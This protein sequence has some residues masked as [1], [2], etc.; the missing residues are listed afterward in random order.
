MK[1]ILSV[2]LFLM[3]PAAAPSQTASDHCSVAADKLTREGKLVRA[4]G[5]VRAKADGLELTGDEGTCNSDTG[6]VELRGHVET[7]LPARPDHSAF[8]YDSGTLITDKSV[9]LAADRL[10]VKDGLLQGWGNLVIRGVNPVSQEVEV[11]GDEMYMFLRTADS[12][13]SGHIRVS[14]TYKGQQSPHARF[15]IFPPDVVKD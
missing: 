11:R 12:T 10:K 5:H 3:L 1:L 13:V 7:V 8:R 14:G 4:T 6:E 2:S 9:T 15:P